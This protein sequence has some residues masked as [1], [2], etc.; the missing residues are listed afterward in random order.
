MNAFMPSR[1][2]SALFDILRDHSPQRRRWGPLKL[3]GKGGRMVWHWRSQRA[4]MRSIG[5]QATRQLMLA[6]PR[7]MFRPHAQC[8]YRGTDL[9]QRMRFLIAHYAFL[10]RSYDAARYAQIVDERGFDLW[11]QELQETSVAIRLFGPPEHHEGDLALRFLIDDTHI[12]QLAFSIVPCDCFALMPS[13]AS[14][15]R[16]AIYIG[17]VQGVLGQTAL[18]R[19]ATQLCEAIAP[20]DLLMSALA[21]IAT[22]WKIPLLL[23]VAAE[24]HISIAAM[25]A[26]PQTFDYTLFWARYQS[27]MS[28][29]GHHVIEVPFVQKPITEI[30]NRHRKRT[31]RKRRFKEA[32]VEEVSM[33]VWRSLRRATDSQDP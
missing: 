27:L 6:R 33:N 10:N 15:S 32:L 8:L 29:D 4:F 13:A 5:G 20:Q 18:I 31:L 25:M 24:R 26:S 7:M 2:R 11:S 28:L 12:F 19:R 21:G 17:Q 14:D 22:A 9:A 30:V 16:H 23:G 1:L 3:L